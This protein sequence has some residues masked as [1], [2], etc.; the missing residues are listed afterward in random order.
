MV[1]RG[2]HGPF[3]GLQLRF[4]DHSEKL[5]YC[6]LTEIKIVCNEK[7]TQEL[8]IHE[9]KGLAALGRLKIVTVLKD[10]VESTG[11]Q[12]FTLENS[13]PKTQKLYF[14][15]EKKG[16]GLNAD[17][18]SMKLGQDTGMDV[19]L[20]WAGHIEKIW[21]DLVHNLSPEDRAKVKDIR[22][23]MPGKLEF[24]II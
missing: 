23:E 17:V 21:Q 24:Y 8:H 22:I 11:A 12:L 18:S 14:V 7:L 20:D 9:G 3:Y 10:F 2:V 4:I 5:T 16:L 1:W 13:L 19:L 6:V 15:D